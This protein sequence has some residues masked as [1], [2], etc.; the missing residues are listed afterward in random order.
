MPVIT[1]QVI[2]DAARDGR[3]R[4]PVGEGDL[5]S[6]LAPEVA[7]RL[8]IELVRGPLEAPAPVTTDP[9]RAIRRALYR[10]APKWVAAGPRRGG[11]PA[12]FE[13]IAFVGAGAVGATTAHLAAMESLA[14]ELVL[15]DIVPGLAAS[16]ALDIE[17]ASGITHS[18]TRARGGTALELV[19]DAD[20]VVVTAGRPRTP[21][22][23]RSALLEINGSLM[24]NV[25]EAITQ[26]AG[27][28]TVIVVTNPVDEMTHEVWRSCGLPARRI[29]GMAGTLDSSRF[30]HALARAAG[31]EPVDVEAVT[32]GSHGA[33]MVPI[34]SRATIK[35]RPAVDVLG[36]ERLQ[37]CVKETI[38]G[39]AAVVA[40]R[41]TGSA[42]VAPAHAIVEILEA[43]RGAQVGAVPVSAYLEGEYGIEGVFLGVLANLGSA[44]VTGIE[45]VRLSEAELR[46]LRSA[47]E[48]I[49]RR[50]ESGGRDAR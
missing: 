4:V 36:R 2:R 16:I 10:R 19:T 23:E 31:V 34:V 5:V 38:E 12:R 20:V 32:L 18:P 47:A 44:G 39:G 28:A 1:E 50:L 6:P 46:R 49:R 37:A 11:R 30:R 29:L 43:M 45:E 41:R 9:A 48:A 17:H 21:G 13:R 27:D 42:S 33:E 7:A 26:H 40:L 8:G 24:R 35:G 15:I 3:R 14:D 25:G 22:M